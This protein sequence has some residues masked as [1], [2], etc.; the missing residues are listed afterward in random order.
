MAVII[1]RQFETVRVNACTLS[2]FDRFYTRSIVE[3]RVLSSSHPE[4]QSAVLQDA[5]LPTM[6]LFGYMEKTRQIYI[7][8]NKKTN[9]VGYS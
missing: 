5:P 7:F 3:R 2:R 6:L 1:R 8:R 9:H 4:S